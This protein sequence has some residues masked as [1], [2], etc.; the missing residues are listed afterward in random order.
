MDIYFKLK[1]N[2]LESM[3]SIP[4][5]KEKEIQ[6]LVENNLEELFNLTFLSTEFRIKNQI[7]DTLC[8]DE[9]SKSFVIIEYKN[10]VSKSVSDQGMAYLSTLMNY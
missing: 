4:F 3:N 5:S 7:F 1:N 8:F 10:S 2:K 9:D 6:N